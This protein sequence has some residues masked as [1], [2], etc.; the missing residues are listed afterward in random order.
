MLKPIENTVREIKKLDGLWDFCLDVRQEGRAKEYFRQALPEGETRK[1]AVPASYNDI[2]SDPA[3]KNHVGDVWYQR[4]VLIPSFCAD[5]RVVLRFNAVTHRGTVWVNDTLV[6]EHQGGYLPFEADITSLVHPGDM[7]RITVCCNNE[8]NWQTLPPGLVTNNEAGEKR[9]YYFH[10]FF[11]YA[12]IHRSVELYVTPK[13]YIEDVTVTTDVSEDCT[14]GTV[15]VDFTLSAGSTESKAQVRLFDSNNHCVAVSEVAVAEGKGK[16]QIALSGAD[17]HLWQPGQ[18][19]LYNLVI[20]T[21]TDEY[22]LRVGVRSVEVKGEQFLI[23]HKPFYFKGFGRH[24]DYIVRGKGFD[25]VGMI[26]DH[27]LMDWIG[28]NSYRTSHYPYAEEQ[29]DYADEHGLVVIDETQTVGLNLSLGLSS[30]KAG[31][32][33]KLFSEEGINAQT[34]ANHLQCIKELIARDKN[35]PC[36]VLWSIA[37]EPDAAQ[38]GAREYFEPLAKATRELDPSRPI[39]CVN[40]MFSDYK[41]DLISD[42]FDVLCLNRYYGWYVQSGD[43]SA[44][45]KVLIDELNGWQNKLHKPIIITEYGTD[46][47]AGLHSMCAEMWTEEYQCLWLNMYHE[48]FSNHSAVVGEQIWNFADFMTS[49]GVLRVGGNRKGIFTRDRQP[50]QSAYVVRKRWLSVPCC[51]KPQAPSAQ[52]ATPY[53]ECALK[54]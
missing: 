11:N 17:L 50:K 7:V 21:S 12:G 14:Q 13:D 26:Q 6:A 36:V 20:S 22:T 48:V 53:A 5:K 32:P 9:Q 47:M 19:Y 33:K 30:D 34:Q 27:A 41:K 40:V 29:M 42:F 28:A 8:L 54:K 52:D 38:E 3:Y 23:N 35:H 49:E 39:T 16:C 24:E 2:F 4:N 1:I 43:L 44:A 51:E 31:L 25:Y 45:R 37:N 10:D 15:N 46:T 18:G